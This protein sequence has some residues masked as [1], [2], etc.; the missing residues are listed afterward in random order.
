VLETTTTAAPTTT[1]PT[2]TAPTTTVDPFCAE[3]ADRTATA[4]DAIDTTPADPTAL[5]DSLRAA[6]DYL[7][8]LRGEVP[9]DL[10]PNVDALLELGALADAFDGKPDFM[11]AIAEAM[12][13]FIYYEDKTGFEDPGEAEYAL[14]D[15][16]D[17]ACGTGENEV[18]KAVDEAMSILD[19]EPG[20]EPGDDWEGDDWE[21][22]DGWDEPDVSVYEGPLPDAPAGFC[23]SLEE[24]AWS[25]LPSLMPM[26][27]GMDSEEPSLDQV[28]EL[29]SVIDPIYGWLV[30]NVPAEL[31]D[32]AQ[33][34][35]VSIQSMADTF[36]N[37]D[38]ETTSEDEIGM[39]V[40]MAL[41]GAMGSE[42]ADLETASL[43]LDTFLNRSCNVPMGE[44]PL[45]IIEVAGG[46]D[47]PP[48]TTEPPPPT[49]TVDPL[50]DA[51]RVPDDY[52]TIQEAVDAAQPGD[53]VL[54]GPGTYHEAVIVETDDIVIRGTD[55]NEP[56]TALDG[57]AVYGTSNNFMY[58][59]PGDSL[60]PKSNDLWKPVIG[61]VNGMAC[62][63]AFYFLA[64]CDILIAAEHATFFDPHVTYGMAAVYEPMKMLTRMPFGEVMRMSLT[65]SAERISAATAQRMGLVTEVVPG[66]ELDAAATRLAETIAANPPWAVQGTLRAIW[67]AQDLGRLA[68]RDVA[69]ALYAAAVDPAEMAAGSSAFE[70]GVRVEPRIR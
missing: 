58:D 66:D 21:G 12:P 64:E 36:A 9:A 39:M 1:A 49:T 65:G 15:Y 53:L 60:G 25:I 56:F 4:L 40:L 8:W 55:R 38:P 10:T 45:A 23:S 33:A 13:V 26:I 62:G 17:A 7:S 35:R 54:I 70:S 43:R 16:L 69:P 22:D 37:I 63:G 20:D 32:D 51:L 68:A 27:S 19:D 59:D 24:Q 42:A 18:F 41:M 48:P 50:A 28:T 67:A 6:G 47:E 14:D 46:G 61:A 2:T 44:G 52:A 29:F 5:A 11:A 30:E 3:H 34:V 31:T 57:P